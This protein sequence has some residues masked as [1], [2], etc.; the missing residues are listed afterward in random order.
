MWRLE[1]GAAH[2][3]GAW[4]VLS[5]PRPIDSAD[6]AARS[7][8]GV[9]LEWDAAATAALHGATQLAVRLAAYYD[10]NSLDYPVAVSNVARITLIGPTETPTLEPTQT[11]LPIPTLDWLP[12]ATPTPE[13]TSIPSSTP[14]VT[15]TPSPALEITA[16]PSATPEVTLPSPTPTSEATPEPAASVRAAISLPTEAAQVQGLVEIWGAADGTGFRRYVVEYT[17]APVPQASDWLPVAE[18]FMPVSDGLLA[19]WPAGTL[20]PGSY[21]LRLRVFDFTGAASSAQVQVAVV[22]P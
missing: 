12:T 18:L 14:E 7:V 1:Y 2:D 11:P 13:L 8:D 15:A 4:G 10:V 19:I 21:W 22:G 20:A 3:P 9:L 16:T 6:G 5:G 17:A